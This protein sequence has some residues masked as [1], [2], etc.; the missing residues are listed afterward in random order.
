MPLFPPRLYQREPLPWE[1]GFLAGKCF[2]RYRRLGERTEIAP[3]RFLHRGS[4]CH[5]ASGIAHPRRGSLSYLFPHS[6][7]LSAIRIHPPALIQ[8]TGWFQS[9]FLPRCHRLGHGAYALHLPSTK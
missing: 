3:A 6:R 2:L 5:P 4:R 7:S 8:Q 9:V 1:A